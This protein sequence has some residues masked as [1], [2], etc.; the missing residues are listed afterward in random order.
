[1]LVATDPGLAA[2]A[3]SSALI[4]EVHWR[5]QARLADRDDVLAE[6]CRLS[7]SQIV[8]RI[9]GS[10]LLFLGGN[11]RDAAR[12]V[13]A[14]FGD[15]PCRWI[16]QDTRVLAVSSP[17]LLKAFGTPRPKV[18]WTETLLYLLAT[19]L[20]RATTCLAGVHELPSGACLEVAE[21]GANVRPVWSPWP[22]AMDA[23]AS[24]DPGEAAERVAR[25]V[26][27]AVAGRTAAAKAS[28]LL[29]SGGL[30]SAVVA[31][32]MARAGRSFASLNMVTRQRSGDERGYARAVADA[33]GS[34][35]IERLRTTEAI[36]WDDPAPASLPR[37]SHRIFRQPSLVAA[38]SVAA[39]HGADLVIDGG[40][41]DNMFCSL[42]SV[43][44]VLDRL[45]VAG[46]GRGAWQSAREM[47]FLCDVGLGAIACK[48]VE[49]LIT[50]RVRFGW[51]VDP[52][53]LVRDA[54]DLSGQ[55]TAHPWLEPPDSALPGQAAH[56]ALVLAA[57]SL[58]DNLPADGAAAVVS[59]LVAQPLAEAVLGVRSWLWFANGRNR[60]PVRQGF[61]GRL[62]AR[63]LARQGKGTP[64]GFMAEIVGSERARLRELLLDGLL[65]ANG[66]A[67]RAALE[68]FLSDSGPPRDFDFARVLQI[69][70]AERWARLWT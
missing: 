52:S 31:A 13:R 21:E 47:A 2:F 42:Q 5:G 7:P 8:D 29:L 18:A 16:D 59:P 70:D 45:Q 56:V 49:R 50:R 36:D 39:E 27:L 62:P 48:L 55:A 17:G 38:R 68:A 20:P 61:A 63:S 24:D 54:L 43:A 37:P 51:L 19:E 22:F 1:M 30:D 40:G 69:A 26:D 67:D 12:I 3:P 14:P 28:V 34:P 4:G 46:L 15:I 23:V 32:A 25:A 11:G 6:V 57:S 60:A 64:A 41:G 44:P 35:F 33:T 66:V 10:Y 65:V 58:A 9:W 53:F